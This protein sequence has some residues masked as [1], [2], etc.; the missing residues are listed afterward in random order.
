MRALRA[1]LMQRQRSYTQP[2]QIRVRECVERLAALMRDTSSTAD[3]IRDAEATLKAACGEHE[4]VRADL[5]F[6]RDLVENETG[7]S[8]FFRPPSNSLNRNPINTAR[9]L[10]GVVTSVPILVQHHHWKF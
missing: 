2:S 3:E 1:Q 5:R 6:K 8:F 4:R 10:N 7:S 9:D